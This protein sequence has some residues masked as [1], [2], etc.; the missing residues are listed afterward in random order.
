MKDLLY[1]LLKTS[2]CL[3]HFVLHDHLLFSVIPKPNQ[4]TTQAS[5]HPLRLLCMF[6]IPSKF[7]TAYIQ[8]ALLLK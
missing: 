3:V 5:L 6:S 2:T 4:S 8:K 7:L 1:H